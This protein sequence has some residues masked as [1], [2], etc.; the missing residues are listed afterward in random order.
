MYIP[1]AFAQADLAVLHD[2]ID[3]YSFGLLVSSA[4]G[5]PFA[6]H[7]P[8]LLDRS[9]GPN[10]SLAGH[11]AAANPHARLAPGAPVMAVFAGPHA[12]VSPSW[13]EAEHVV[14]TWN[15]VAVH[16]YGLFEPIGDAALAE[17]LERSAAKYEKSRPAPWAFDSSTNFARKMMNQVVGFRIAV[18]RLEGKWKLSQNQPA[19]RRARV[20]DALSQGDADARAVAEW[21]KE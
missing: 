5:A 13:Y 10:G 15:Y 11:V 6:T 14:P 12:Y 21:M 19:E 1:P 8:L 20:R 17:L 4:D 2:F 7:L 18:Q 16:A 9:A 3:R